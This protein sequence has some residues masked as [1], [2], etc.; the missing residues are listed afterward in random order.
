MFNSFPIACQIVCCQLP[1]GRTVWNL[2]LA[3]TFFQ[4][5]L[6]KPMQRKSDFEGREYFDENPP[7]PRKS[8]TSILFLY[9]QGYETNIHIILICVSVI[10]N[11]AFATFM[12]RGDFQ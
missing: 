11:E 1:G 10:G 12:P 6:N 5:L 3:E 9:C 2:Y 8:L 7:P 4:K